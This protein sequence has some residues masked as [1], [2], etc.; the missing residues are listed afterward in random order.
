[1]DLAICSQRAW[2]G[3]HLAWVLDFPNWARRLVQ[4]GTQH[5]HIL[6]AA[7]IAIMGG[8]IGMIS[9][10]GRESYSQ[11]RPCAAYVASVGYRDETSGPRKSR[12]WW[13]PPVPVMG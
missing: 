3:P 7:R 6:G 10:W 13:S 9:P 12:W 4:S 5:A 11:I 2:H 8:G 1:M